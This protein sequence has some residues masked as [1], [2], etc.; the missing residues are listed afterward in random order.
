MESIYVDHAATTPL[1]PQVLKVMHNFMTRQFGNPSS[2]HAFGREAKAAL[3]ESR[4]TIAHLLGVQPKEIIFTSGGTEADNLA[5]LGTA[6]AYRDKGTH[7]LSSQAE[8]H[9]VLHAL[10]VLERC[11]FEVTYLP[12]DENGRVRP[13]EVE[14]AIRPNTVLVSLILANNETGTINPIAEI[15][16]LLRERGIIFHTD[17]VQALGGMSLNLAS[18]PVDLVSFSAHKIYGPKGMGC[19]YIRDGIKLHPLL[20]GG[21]QERGRR[22]GT[23]NVPAVVGFAEAFKLASLELEERVGKYERLKRCLLDQLAA[24]GVHFILNGDEKHSV[25]HILNVSFPGVKAS[26]LLMN[27]DLAG[28]AASSGSACT[29]GSLTPSHVI[30]AMHHD[31]DRAQS[32]IRFSFGLGNTEQEMKEVAV[33]TAE[34]INRIRD[35]G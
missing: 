22:A 25:P 35:K 28:I 5:V 12:V 4:R 11:G 16:H 6:L 29:A 9:A 20:Y 19:L 24:Q 32:A 23:E 1:H 13:E 30:L 26:A 27:L 18:L 17:A 2:I 3:E 14:Q 21:S 15:G 10:Q 31:E 7:V 8:H 34:I 33:K